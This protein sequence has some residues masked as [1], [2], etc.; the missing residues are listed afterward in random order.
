ML[1]LGSIITNLIL[2]ISL[3]LAAA[4]AGIMAYHFAKAKLRERE[5]FTY[6]PEEDTVAPSAA[7]D[8]RA[9]SA[10]EITEIRSR[11]EALMEEQTVRTETQGQHLAQ[12]MDEIR[13]HMGQQ[14]AKMDG[15]KSELRHEIQRRNTELDE[16]RGQ[17]ASAL[18][19]FWKSMPVLPEARSG[20]S[21]ALPP[22]QGVEETEQYQPEQTEEP[23]LNGFDPASETIDHTHEPLEPQEP[24]TPDFKTEGADWGAMSEDAIDPFEAEDFAPQS[25]EEADALENEQDVLYVDPQ[26]VPEEIAPVESGYSDSFNSHEATLEEATF[27]PVSMET[28]AFAFDQPPTEV[29][30]SPVEDAPPS[31]EEPASQE[32]IYSY[33]ETPTPPVPSANFEESPHVAEEEGNAQSIEEASF[34]PVEPATFAPINPVNESEFVHDDIFPDETSLSREYTSSQEYSY[35]ATPP[36][37]PASEYQEVDT[38]D[39]QRPHEIEES[40]EQE[41]SPVAPS[42]QASDLHA[43]PP[44]IPTADFDQETNVDAEPENDEFD[45]D[46]LFTPISALTY[47]EDAETASEE[48]PAPAHGSILDAAQIR[49]GEP[50]FTPSPAEAEKNFIDDENTVEE[51]AT[52][53]P[54]QTAP[55]L[56]SVSDVSYS[57][58]SNVN[59]AEEHEPATSFES[60]VDAGSDHEEQRNEPAVTPDTEAIA[61]LQESSHPQQ[62]APPED[63]PPVAA[64]GS[65]SQLPDEN[66][67]D[68]LTRIN[69]IDAE[70]QQKLYSIGVTTLDEV[71]RWSSSDARTIAQQVGVSEDDIRRSWI[72]EAQSILFDQ[73]QDQLQQQ[74]LAQQ[75]A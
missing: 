18:D 63:R 53:Q 17:L 50:Q 46:S 59:P 67:G 69:G 48:E 66:S 12:K 34:A 27:E 56:P 36:P 71:A 24:P 58:G 29:D 35:A 38:E 51:S 20:D 4:V 64:S 45:A 43:K 7:A 68:D 65:T 42:Y 21:L 44:P 49:T 75:Q 8:A 26:T 16:L 61:T 9:K 32:D 54:A 19:A 55:D 13:S 60:S 57:G 11:I 39:F 74:Q 25:F 3:V 62:A 30:S 5:G 14:D 28:E 52:S 72:F 15:I 73:Y 41:S 10:Q 1:I 70:L 47:P 2:G 40:F 33:S 22:A 37:L 31:V 23:E 6:D